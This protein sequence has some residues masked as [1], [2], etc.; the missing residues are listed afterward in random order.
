M[1]RSRGAALVLVLWLIALMTA[2]V[3]AFALSARVEHLQERV[4]DDDARGQ[5]RARA[6][7][8]YA[9]MR[10]SPDP[11]RAPWQADG[12][13]YR[14]QFDGARIEIQV[15]DENGKINLN[16]ADVALL[17]AYLQAL[18]EPVDN[19]RQLAGAIVDWRDEDS[20]LQPGGG[21]E[22]QDYA[23]AGLPYGPRNKRFET[24]G[25][26]QRVLGMNGP[27]YR[28]MLPHLTLYSRQARPDPRFASAPVLTALGLDADLVL[29]QRN[30]PERDGDPADGS[31][32]L[33]SSSG[34]YSI[35]SR[36]ID[37]SGRRSVLQAVVRNGSGGIPGRSYTV[38]RWEQGMTAR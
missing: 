6:G 20:L 33:A 10:L 28:K 38:L 18:G 13:T 2:L 23:A 27:L 4:L 37:G 31:S 26:L 36:V 25:E 7:L 9:L 22:A 32:A 16:L 30:Q 34:T 1:M 21:A 3:G 12:R 8:E 29:A 24:L 5:E 17:T 15:L 14:W 35:E 19:A 11:L